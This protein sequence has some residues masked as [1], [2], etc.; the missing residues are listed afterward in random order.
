M[1]CD[2]Y[3]PIEDYAL[4]GDGRTAALVSRDGS[5]DWLCLPDFDSPSVLG[6]LLDSA[7]GGAFELRPAVPFEVKRRYLPQTNVVETTFTTA[8]GAVR[9]VDALTLPTRAIA[10]F[11]ELARRVEEGHDGRDG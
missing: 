6:A 3:A 2:G 9:V 1:R 5:I 7:R 11:R 4:I 8:V 10:P